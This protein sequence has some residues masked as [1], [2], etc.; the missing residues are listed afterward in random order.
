MFISL[1]TN[2]YSFRHTDLESF[3][4]E[5]TTFQFLNGTNPILLQS[6]ELEMSFLIVSISSFNF[7]KPSLVKYVILLMIIK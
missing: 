7:F 3:S 1:N 5:E 4:N 2:G 6:E